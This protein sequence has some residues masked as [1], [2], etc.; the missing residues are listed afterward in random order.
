[1][2][3]WFKSLIR[4]VKSKFAKRILFVGRVDYIDYE[5]DYFCAIIE[6]QFGNVLDKTFH[7][8][9]IDDPSISN[10]YVGGYFQFIIDCNES[11]AYIK[12]TFYQSEFTFVDHQ[13]DRL[14]LQ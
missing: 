10:L 11:P 6:D 7:I 2:I 13:E 4:R 3:P 5:N 14:P 1:M 9:K 12:W 8:S